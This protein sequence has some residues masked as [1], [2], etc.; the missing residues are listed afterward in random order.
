MATACIC[1]MAPPTTA[2]RLRS[3]T[4]SGISTRRY[5]CSRA[6]RL[7]AHLDDG[8]FFADDR[9]S[10]LEQIHDPISTSLR[11]LIWASLTR[12]VLHRCSTLQRRTAV[13]YDPRFPNDSYFLQTYSKDTQV[14]WYG[15][16][17]Y[18]FTKQWQLTLGARESRMQLLLQH[19][20]RRPAALPDA[21]DRQRRENG[22][23]LHAQGEPLLPVRPERSLL[24]DLRQGIPAGR[25][26]Q[27]GT[28]RGL[29]DDFQNFG[30]SSRRRPSAPTT[31]NSYEV[32]AKNNID[33]RVQLATSIYY[34]QWNNIQQTVV[35]P[36]CQISFIANLGQAVAKGAD[37][38]R[39]IV[40]VAKSHG[41]DHAG[42]TD[43]RYRRTRVSRPRKSRPS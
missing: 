17:T 26:Q 20:D 12:T 4:T 19:A 29:R 38:D 39:N 37:M 6:T 25:R 43:A 30:I 35:P 10:Y 9:Q 24:R 1:R 22:E 15:Q 41:R 13:T 32:G 14:A 8:L 3:T 42:Y 28:L 33:G 34:I 18:A 7:R 27:S 5:G 31:V 36:I 21:A 40:L 11:R 2:R 16:A 23:C